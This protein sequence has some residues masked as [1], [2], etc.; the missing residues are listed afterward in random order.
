MIKLTE[1]NELNS[2]QEYDKV[3]LKRKE[4][5]VDEQ[6]L[7]S[8]HRQGSS[9]RTRPVQLESDTMGRYGT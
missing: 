4:N 8:P 1:Q 6:D 9:G 5:G 7:R 3:F 2:A